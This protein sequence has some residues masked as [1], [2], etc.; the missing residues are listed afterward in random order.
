MQFLSSFRANQ[1]T[2]ARVRC[3]RRLPCAL[4]IVWRDSPS[5]YKRNSLAIASRCSSL[6]LFS[7]VHLRILRRPA[8]RLA[9]AVYQVNKTPAPGRLL[10]AAQSRARDPTGDR[11]DSPTSPMSTIL[12]TRSLVAHVRYNFALG[13]TRP[14]SRS[15]RRSSV[16]AD[17]SRAAHV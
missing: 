11:R 16:D 14:R 4:S 1:Y 15:R 12:G 10:A 2:L 5:D 3:S 9:L 7:L 8:R 6:L 13:S 17:F